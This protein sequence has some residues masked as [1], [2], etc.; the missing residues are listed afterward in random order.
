MGLVA[1]TGFMLILVPVTWYALDSFDKSILAGIVIGSATGFAIAQL[2]L[3]GVWAA[4]APGR[5]FVRLPWSL[6]LLTLYWFA[7]IFGNRISGSLNDSRSAAEVI[8][9]LILIGY[10]A[11]QIPLWITSRVGR[12]RL[13]PPRATAE[14]EGGQFTIKEM[15]IATTVLAVVIGLARVI[16]PSSLDF[17]NNMLRDRVMFAMVSALLIC[18]LLLVIPCVWATCLPRKSIA[19]MAS[20]WLLATCIASAIEISVLFGIGGAP[21]DTRETLFIVT[22]FVFINIAQGVTVFVIMSILKQLGYRLIRTTKSLSA[23]STSP[24]AKIQIEES[25]VT[26]STSSSRSR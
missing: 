5:I 15:I 4:L 21:S 22:I 6:V 26:I 23:P 1:T 9:P 24:F 3:I 25:R 8:G 12:W 20:G 17:N 13:M 14:D 10:V 2:N 7:L 18:N 19:P 16:V 11:L